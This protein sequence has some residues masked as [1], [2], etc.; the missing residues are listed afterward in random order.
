METIRQTIL[1]RRPRILDK[2]ERSFKDYADYKDEYVDVLE[3]QLCELFS[4]AYEYF[5][6]KENKL[7]GRESWLGQRERIKPN[8]TIYTYDFWKMENIEEF[9]FGFKSTKGKN[10]GRLVIDVKWTN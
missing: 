6:K 8:K 5:C 7:V 9:S 10:I 4:N 1:M 3:K 2:T